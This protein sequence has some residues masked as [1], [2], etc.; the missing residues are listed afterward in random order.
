VTDSLYQSGSVSLA[1][2]SLIAH[3]KPSVIS[4]LS[5]LKISF[6][7]LLKLNIFFFDRFF[8]VSVIFSIMTSWRSFILRFVGASFIVHVDSSF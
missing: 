4:E 6:K 2:A 1:K 5:V 8:S 7:I 3:V